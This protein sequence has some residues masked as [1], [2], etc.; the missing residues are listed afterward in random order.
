MYNF[1]KKYKIN[2]NNC[3]KIVVGSDANELELLEKL[4]YNGR[5]N[6]V[7]DLELLSGEKVSKRE[8]IIK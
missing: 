1:A 2:H 7:R 5:Q 4:M 3:G 6:D 8:P